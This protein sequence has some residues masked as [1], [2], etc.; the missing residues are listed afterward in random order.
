MN[1]TKLIQDELNALWWTSANVNMET[2]VDH[3]KPVS[4]SG[5][6]LLPVMHRTHGKLYWTRGSAEA[7][8]LAWAFREDGRRAEVY[9]EVGERG[10]VV[11]AGS[12]IGSN[13]CL[14]RR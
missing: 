3:L 11:F 1:R 10:L 5:A 2:K 6:L 13:C 14:Q 7:L 8:L 4:K 9:W 12:P